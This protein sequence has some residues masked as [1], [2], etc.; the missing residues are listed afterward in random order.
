MPRLLLSRRPF[1]RQ[2]YAFPRVKVRSRDTIVRL[3][4]NRD[5]ALP[6]GSRDGRACCKCNS[7]VIGGSC[8]YAL[9]AAAFVA[10]TVACNGLTVK[11]MERL[12]ML[13]ARPRRGDVIGVGGARRAWR[14]VDMNYSRRRDRRAFSKSGYGGCLRDAAIY[15]VGRVSGPTS[16][17][18]KRR[19][20]QVRRV[21][22]YRK[23]LPGGN[24]RARARGKCC[25]SHA[26]Q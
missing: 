7:R 1:G 20:H 14:G 17:F 10:A 6:E 8:V 22:V 19:R 16:D 24:T 5:S 2:A 15:L 3:T 23:F 18:P 13:W 11:L 21:S 26:S 9:A 25:N 4:A 12:P